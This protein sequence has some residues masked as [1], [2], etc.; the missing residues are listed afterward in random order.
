[1]N[2]LIP[3]NAN[4]DLD[5]QVKRNVMKVKGIDKLLEL[6]KQAVTLHKLAK[7]AREPKSVQNFYMAYA[8][9]ARREIGQILIDDLDFGRGKVDKVS[10]LKIE[11][12]ETKRWQ[13]LAKIEGKV[14][15]KFVKDSKNISFNKLYGLITIQER[16]D[17]IA[18]KIYYG[19]F[20]NICKGWEDGSID[21]IVTDPPYPEEFL[22]EWSDLSEVA[23][24]ILK[25]SG[26][27]I[28]YAGQ[29]HLP[30][31][32]NRL[33]KHLNYYW[34]MVFMQTFHTQIFPRKIFARYKPILVF[35]KSPVEVKNDWITDVIKPTVQKDIM[36]W[37]QDVE[38][39]KQIISRFTKQGEV[40]LDPFAGSGTAGMACKELQR[41]F[42]L[43]DDGKIFEGYKNEEDQ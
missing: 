5:V 26:Y 23:S 24:R 12:H 34:Q 14:F 35:Q 41:E 8:S 2:E 22:Q 37:Q 30:D 15:D 7:K 9:Y 32:I 43:I 1:M 17:I 3:Y 16:Y 36:D 13:K 11:Y 27:C 4:V 19:R 21:H 28:C 33:S 10:T 39:Y 40:I 42:T 6:D 25:P 38:S 29:T 20:Q 18:P 31:Y